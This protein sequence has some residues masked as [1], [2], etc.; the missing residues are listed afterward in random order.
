[1]EETPAARL[2]EGHRNR[3]YMNGECCLRRVRDGHTF[4]GDNLRSSELARPSLLL[5]LS[6]SSVS[7]VT[8]PA[9][10]SEVPL[11]DAGDRA[12][13]G[14]SVFPAH[15]R[16]FM[17]LFLLDVVRSII[18]PQHPEAIVTDAKGRPL[19]SPRV[20]AAI[21]CHRALSGCTRMRPSQTQRPTATRTRHRGKLSYKN[22]SSLGRSMRFACPFSYIS[23]LP[24]VNILINLL[25][26]TCIT[27]PAQACHSHLGHIGGV[28]S[29]RCQ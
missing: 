29:L 1:M 15:V 20:E 3:V 26:E 4:G 28:Q 19:H 6:S 8:L 11:P 12:S 13:S 22:Y 27:K 25:R 10:C 7:V 14:F 17:R 5:L 18:A 23:S 2:R 9:P 24:L 16:R 21:Q